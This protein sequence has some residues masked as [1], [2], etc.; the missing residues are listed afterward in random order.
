MS[1]PLSAEL[2]CQLHAQNQ[3]CLLCSLACLSSQLRLLQVWSEFLLVCVSHCPAAAASRLGVSRTA[4]V[5]MLNYV[6]EV[7]NHMPLVV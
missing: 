7:R 5:E 3:V 1:I 2:S 6:C 4:S